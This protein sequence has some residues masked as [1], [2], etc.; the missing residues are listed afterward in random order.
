MVRKGMVAPSL[1]QKDVSHS[2]VA[3]VSI[4]Y[5]GSWII[6]LTQKNLKETCLLSYL[7]LHLVFPQDNEHKQQ[8]VGG[9]LVPAKQSSITVSGQSIP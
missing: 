3:R 6:F 5:H 4:T 9:I 1:S 8:L 2:M 7:P